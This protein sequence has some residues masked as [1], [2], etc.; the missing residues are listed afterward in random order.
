MDKMNKNDIFPTKV[1]DEC[2][3]TGYIISQGYPEL[4]GFGKSIC[5]KCNGR[6]RQ[7]NKPECFRALSKEEL[8]KIEPISGEAIAIAMEEGRKIRDEVI[9]NTSIPRINMNNTSFP[10]K[11]F[12]MGMKDN[13]DKKVAVEYFNRWQSDIK[14]K[15]HNTGKYERKYIEITIISKWHPSTEYLIEILDHKGAE[16]N[17]DNPYFIVS[18]SDS[19]FQNSLD[20]IDM[21]INQLIESFKEPADL[22]MVL[23]NGKRYR[24][25]EIK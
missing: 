15:L 23:K 13:F 16:F 4:V 20:I 24:L 19:N 17:D 21:K 5:D 9:E 6:E 25:V 7:L 18:A 1:C 3:D 11:G 2:N 22:S 12:A 14:D 8:D 10:N